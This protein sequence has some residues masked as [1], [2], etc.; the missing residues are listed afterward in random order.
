MTTTETCHPPDELERYR[1]YLRVVARLHLGRA[2]T[3]HVDASDLVQE[4]LL[5]AYEARAEYQ[6]QTDDERRAWLRKILA[7]AAIDA[8]RRL[9]RQKRNW[10]LDRSIEATVNESAFRL[11]S[12]LAAD[13]TSPSE[14]VMRNEQLV[15]LADALCR[16]PADQRLAVELH[17]LGNLPV[18]NV[19]IVMDKSVSSV[20][21]LLRRGL[22]SLREELPWL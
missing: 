5:K 21:G 18:S 2:L 22:A 13:Q 20:A 11:E 9:G 14:C 10:M 3:P 17:H 1:A 15:W 7:R 4:T 6:G 16:L 19:A 12:A 8:C